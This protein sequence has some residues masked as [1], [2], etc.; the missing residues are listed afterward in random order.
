MSFIPISELASCSFKATQCVVSMW[1]QLIHN[2]SCGSTSS[3]CKYIFSGNIKR[4]QRPLFRQIGSHK[5]VVRIYFQEILCTVEFSTSKEFAAKEILKYPKKEHININK[6]CTK[7]LGSL[8]A[9]LFQWNWSINNYCQYIFSFQY[10]YKWMLELFL[11]FL[12]W[13]IY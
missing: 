11:K 5:N 6:T 13:K 7:L 12:Q 2:N 9:E 10:F 3:L 4:L 1:Q 8:N